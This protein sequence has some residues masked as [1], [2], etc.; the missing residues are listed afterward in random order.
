SRMFTT[1]RPSRCPLPRRKSGRVWP[2]AEEQFLDGQRM[3]RR[4][5]ISLAGGAAVW[6][7]AAR[8]Q[9]SSKRPTIGFLG[10]DAAAWS[11]WT[12][13]FV[14]RLRAL[15]WLEGRTI[16]IE[17]RWWEGRPE[18]AT[19]IAAEFIRMKVDVI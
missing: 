8:A 16:A 3:H 5:F 12:A 17:Y 6:P 11:P 2:W 7:L 14:E 18:R 15:D 1:A 19:E 10:A 9:Q 4:Q 13:A